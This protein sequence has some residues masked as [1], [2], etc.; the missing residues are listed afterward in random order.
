MNILLK[1]FISSIYLLIAIIFIG[2]A[3]F[4]ALADH[5]KNQT[6]LD[7]LFMTVITITTI[8]YGEVIVFRDLEIGRLYTLIIAI[9]G[10]GAFTYIIS[11]FTAFII[12]GELI[13]K[14]KTRKMEKEIS[15]LSDHYIICGSGDTG[16]IIAEEL[17][18]TK[19]SFVLLDKQEH[20]EQFVNKNSV[21]HIEGDATSESVLEKAGI[22]KAKGLFAVT[23]DENYNLVIT[24]TAR[25][26]NPELRIVGK[27]KEESNIEKIK[28]AGADAVISPNRI[29]GLR[30]VSEMI[31]PTV[32]TF[33][34]KML[35]D[36]EKNLRVE[37]AEIGGHYSGKKVSELK[38]ASPRA[39]LMALQRGEKWIFN[40]EDNLILEMNDVAIFMV[41]PEEK[42][43]LREIIG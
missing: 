31:R 15:A 1:R 43:R 4:Y 39:L 7:A 36:K 21:L 30:I 9:S 35:R 28:K 12:G 40:P 17:M 23:G 16:L 38:A 29:G 2:T 14:I 20:L 22:K 18:M 27:C 6:I 37:E 19:R 11:N 3:G 10:I 25:H 41:E 42:I 26:M 5:S 24:F 13:K 33:L 32:V 8:G 34:D